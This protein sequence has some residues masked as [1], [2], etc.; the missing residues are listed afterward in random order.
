M[1][2]SAS[3]PASEPDAHMTQP[4]YLEISD[5]FYL[6]LRTVCLRGDRF[7]HVGSC[8]LVSSKHVRDHELSTNRNM[9]C[10]FQ[11]LED[12]CFPFRHQCSSPSEHPPSY[13]I[14]SY[15]A[16][17]RSWSVVSNTK[18]PEKKK[19][20]KRRRCSVFPHLN[21]DFHEVSC[22][23]FHLDS[24]EALSTCWRAENEYCIL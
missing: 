24:I 14:A 13:H 15:C 8:S 11:M 4:R 7:S 6:T 23:F 10:L 5:C 1:N 3:K 16:R 19:K 20:K 17:D 18:N 12:L 9:V 2:E 21:Q 22:F